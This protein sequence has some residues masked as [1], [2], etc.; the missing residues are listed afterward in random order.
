[1]FNSNN[2]NNVYQK[3]TSTVLHIINKQIATKQITIRLTDKPFYFY[4]YTKE[5]EAKKKYTPK[6][7]KITKK[8]QNIDKNFAMNL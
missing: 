2:I 6:K 8:I 1:M 4:R 3:F 7:A 5:N